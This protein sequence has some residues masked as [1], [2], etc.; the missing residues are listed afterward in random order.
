M[1]QS[2]IDEGFDDLYYAM[3]HPQ[4]DIALGRVSQHD[5]VY[6]LNNPEKMIDEFYK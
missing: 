5:I 1:M 2:D 4:D 3:L 6:D